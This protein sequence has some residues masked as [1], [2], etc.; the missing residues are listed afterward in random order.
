MKYINL[1]VDNNKIPNKYKTII[2]FFV[3]PM[4][5][6]L[7][8]LI[9]LACNISSVNI[10]VSNIA[11]ALSSVSYAFII[12]KYPPLIQF[13][14]FVLSVA[15][16]CLWSQNNKIIHLLDVTS[17][18]WVITTTTIY[19]LPNAKHSN[20]ILI[21]IN[22]GI[23]TTLIT[24][25]STNYLELVVQWYHEN[26]VV[27]TS[28]IY[29]LCGCFLSCFYLTEKIFITGVAITSFGFCCKLLAL[30]A[31]QVWGTCIFHISTAIGIGILRDI[32]QIIN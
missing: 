12:N 15:S 16:F 1:E 2:R 20:K 24:V 26:I 28:I 3:P 27:C 5:S 30:Y 14:L 4:I 9:V 6:I 10:K 29:S 23:S 25:M 31:N 18:F 19:L 7:T 11:N 21:F 17:I 32:K 8:S 13:P 22:V